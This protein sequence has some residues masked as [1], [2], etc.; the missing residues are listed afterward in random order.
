MSTRLE[1]KVAIITGAGQR[2]GEGVGNGRAT[3]VQFAREGAQLVLAN[4]SI[5]NLEGTRSHVEREGFSALCV[6]CDVSVEDDCRAL[7]DSTRSQYGRIDILHNNVGIGGL[8]GDTINVQQSMWDNTMSINLRG[9]MLLSKHVL[10]VMR[11]QKSG[12]ITHVSSTGAYMSVPLIAYRASKSA[13]NEF[14]RWLAFEN[15]KHNIRANVLMLGFIDT[16]MAIEG[17]HEATGTPRSELRAQRDKAVPMGR[18]GSAWETAKVAAFLASD[19]A[20]YITGA[21][22]PMDGGL[23]TRVG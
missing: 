21:V 18:M 23:L 19:E 1:G 3:A 13:L 12:S 8:E 20:S 6:K 22:L 11:Q 17:Y 7:M 4:R 16:P 14:V 15:A 10:P 2:P 5:E 9:A